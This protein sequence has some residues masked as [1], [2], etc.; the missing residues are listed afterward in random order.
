VLKRG[1]NRIGTIDKMKDSE[2]SLF[3]MLQVFADTTPRSGPQQMALDEAL[4]E[5]ADRPVFRVYCWAE[6]AVSFGY[7][8]SL[9]MVENLFPTRPLVRRW[10]GGGMVEHGRDWTFSLMVPRREAAAGLRSAEAYERIHSAIMKA[11]AVA[12]V[13]G[14]LAGC[15]DRSL[16]AACFVAPALH[17]VL[18]GNGQK[19]CGGAQRRTRLGFLHQ[20]SVQGVEIPEAFGTAVTA[21]LARKTFG[22]RPSGEVEER[23]QILAE[24]KYGSVEWRRKIP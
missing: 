16:G 24:Q 21:F 15:E 2:N 20:G 14:R 9:E 3:E 11:L 5:T 22:F 12:G 10:T 23:A 8:Q 1:L 4:L 19:L 17:D 7:S 18:A 13:A 6:S